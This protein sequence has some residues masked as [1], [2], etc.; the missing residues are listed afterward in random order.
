MVDFN[1]F[2]E[3]C[4]GG[5]D[6]C[7]ESKSSLYR[8]LASAI[9]FLTLLSR[10]LLRQLIFGELAVLEW[11]RGRRDQ[12]R[13]CCFVYDRFPKSNFTFSP[14]I[15]LSE[16]ELS[17]QV[18]KGSQQLINQSSI[19]TLTFINLIQQSGTPMITLN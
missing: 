5:I 18:M 16:E 4:S 10:I 8:R 1:R 11:Q 19:V 13:K 7:G 17:M 14:F 2:I 3:R 15:T 6:G 9:R 12:Y